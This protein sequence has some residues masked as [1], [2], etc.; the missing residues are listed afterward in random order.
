[1]F[2]NV[3]F[4]FL[5]VLIFLFVFWKRLKEDYTHE[6]IFTTGFFVLAGLFLG[7]F[8]SSRFFPTWWFWTSFLGA[9]TG[10]FVGILR[11]KLRIFE[12]LEAGI[13]GLIPWVGLIL[14]Q[15]SI[16]NSSLVSF[17]A[18]IVV[19]GLIVLFFFFDAHYKKFTW[20]KSGRVGFSGLATLGLFFLVRSAIAPI[21]PNVLSF[22]GKYEAIISGILAFVFFLLVFNLSRRQI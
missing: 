16:E 18:F 22:V 21:S 19:L 6:L 11:F 4:T 13:I 20:Y 1:M 10:I 17:L 7:N 3:F 8:V 14:L 15:D 9:F 5:A 12:T 2:Y